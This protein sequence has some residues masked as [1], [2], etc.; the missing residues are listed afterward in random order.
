MVA[1]NWDVK[2]PDWQKGRFT[3]EQQWTFPSWAIEERTHYQFWQGKTDETPI[4]PTFA[5]PEEMATYLID[6]KHLP[7][8]EPWYLVYRGNHKRIAARVRQDGREHLELH[9]R[10][11]EPSS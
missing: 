11:S 7:Q 5:T 4:S 1:P 6:N 3:R 2:N 8:F 10:F 9:R